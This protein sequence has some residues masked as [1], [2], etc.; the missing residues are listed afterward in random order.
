MT[1]KFGNV[2]YLPSALVENNLAIETPATK[3]PKHVFNNGDGGGSLEPRMAKLE[4]SVEHIQADVTHV[5]ADVRGLRED[6]TQ[7]KV[8]VSSIKTRMDFE[9]SAVKA[10]TDSK[11][12]E[13]MAHTD[14]KFS[15]A[16]AHTDSKFLSIE[17]RMDSKFLA[18][19]KELD[20][21]KYDLTSDDSKLSLRIEN[22]VARSLRGMYTMII[23]AL[24]AILGLAFLRL[25]PD[26]LHQPQTSKSH[27]D[28]IHVT[29]RSQPAFSPATKPMP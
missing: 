16:M 27:V 23:T 24:I 8:D 19:H 3:D 9:F 6:V 13:A 20:N 29:P 14:S 5:M 18:V 7:L 22:S 15:E 26:V 2:H 17:L 11:F 1:E 12:S 25:F 28:Q 21:I 10:H 4:A